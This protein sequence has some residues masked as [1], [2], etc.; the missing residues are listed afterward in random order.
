MDMIERYRRIIHYIFENGIVLRGRLIV[1]RIYTDINC[2]SVSASVC[3]L[4]IQVP[5]EV[6]NQRGIANGTSQIMKYRQYVIIQNGQ[7]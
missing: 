6:K 2:E 1:F 3:F 7:M 4:K 5:H